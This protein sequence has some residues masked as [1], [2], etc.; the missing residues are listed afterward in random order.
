MLRRPWARHGRCWAG[1]KSHQQCVLAGTGLALATAVMDVAGEV[2]REED[3]QGDVRFAPLEAS[4]TGSAA[5]TRCHCTTGAAVKPP[6]WP[7][8]RRLSGVGHVRSSFY[9]QE[10]QGAAP[11]DQFQDAC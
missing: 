3:E 7:H 10:I 6:A 2:R 1:R 4:S 9:N 11:D 5:K 8:A